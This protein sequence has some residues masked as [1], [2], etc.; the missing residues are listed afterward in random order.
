VAG[1]RLSKGDFFIV[2]SSD[3]PANILTDY[4]KRWEIET[5]FGCLKSRGFRFEDTHLTKPERISKLFSLLAITFVWAYLTA[6]WLF[7]KQ[8]LIPFKKTIN[9][10]LKSVFR[11]GFEHLRNIILNLQQ[12]FQSF[13]QVVK[14]LSCT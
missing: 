10:P 2:V 13:I 11:Y 1:S 9:R 4:A 14:L 7:K 5:L 6:E 8:K 3:S 12:N